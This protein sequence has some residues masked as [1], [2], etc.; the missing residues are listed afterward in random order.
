MA[1]ADASAIVARRDED[2]PRAATLAIDDWLASGPG[3]TVL[4]A[5]DARRAGPTHVP[6]QGRAAAVIIGDSRWDKLPG[7]KWK[8]SPQTP[9]HQPTPFW[10]SWTD[11]H[12][13]ANTKSAGGSRS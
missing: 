9:I 13:L 6:D 12:V 2:V 11:A 3:Q 8:K 7:G 1:A 10:V 5:L 4:D